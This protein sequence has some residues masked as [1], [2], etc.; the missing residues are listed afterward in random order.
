M[1]LEVLKEFYPYEKRPFRLRDVPSQFPTSRSENVRE[2]MIDMWRSGYNIGVVRVGANSYGFV[3]LGDSEVP[4]I[5]TISKITLE[6]RQSFPYTLFFLNE[7]R[8]HPSGITEKD[9]AKHI[10][11]S[12]RDGE[13]DQIHPTMDDLSRWKYISTGNKRTI[14]QAGRII[15]SKSENNL[16]IFIDYNTDLLKD[17]SDVRLLWAIMKSIQTGSKNP[18]YPF[19]RNNPPYLVECSAILEKYNGA[20]CGQGIL[21]IHDSDNIKRLL[22]RFDVNYEII[23]NSLLIHEKIFFSITPQG[24]IQAQL[25][26]MDNINTFVVGR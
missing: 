8:N 21:K 13:V 26:L 25:N 1:I 19:I 20:G 7:I 23:K 10:F 12:R 2:H 18:T 24:Y 11:R 4:T 15:L 6:F 14:T 9:L 22:S 5:E 17:R 16:L 3:Y